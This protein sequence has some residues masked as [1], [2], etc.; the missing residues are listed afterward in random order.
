[1]YW[2]NLAAPSC[3]IYIRILEGWHGWNKGERLEKFVKINNVVTVLN[4]M[5]DFCCL[6]LKCSAM[7]CFSTFC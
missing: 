4:D 7:F 5:K 2:K 1:M 3:A 6:D